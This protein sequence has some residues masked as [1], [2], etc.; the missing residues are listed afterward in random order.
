MSPEATPISPRAS[1]IQAMTVTNSERGGA[2]IAIAYFRFS[3][4]N[5]STRLYSSSHESARVKPCR[6]S[7]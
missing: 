1:E 6:S 5:F 7:G 3:S 4:N 2:F